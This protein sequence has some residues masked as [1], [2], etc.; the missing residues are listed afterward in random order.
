MLHLCAFALSFPPLASGVQ[1]AARIC[2]TQHSLDRLHQR[3]RRLYAQF[4][5]HTRARPLRLVHKVNIE[6]MIQRRVERV[7]RGEM[8]G[9]CK[10]SCA[11]GE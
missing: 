10:R 5:G 3:A 11:D 2:A 6:G 8:R 9:Y 7:I 1:V 4:H